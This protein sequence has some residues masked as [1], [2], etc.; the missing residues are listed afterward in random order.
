MLLRP[1]DCLLRRVFRDGFRPVHVNKQVRYR[2][3]EQIF[4]Q[5]S[6]KRSGIF[7]LS[8][9]LICQGRHLLPR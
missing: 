3:P 6:G 5:L 2:F 4:R 8:R 1:D 9:C 7:F